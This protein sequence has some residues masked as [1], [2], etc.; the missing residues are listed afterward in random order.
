MEVKNSLTR[1]EKTSQ[2]PLDTIQSLL[3]LSSTGTDGF[4]NDYALEHFLESVMDKTQQNHEIL[5]TH[6]RTVLYMALLSLLERFQNPSKRLI[7]QD[8]II[9]VFSE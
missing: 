6:E 9:D 4:T 2:T 3:D 5:H 7:W 1:E 8:T